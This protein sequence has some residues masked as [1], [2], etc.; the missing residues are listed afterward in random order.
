MKELPEFGKSFSEW[1][2]DRNYAKPAE[3]ENILKQAGYEN[4]EVYLTE[5]QAN[6]N[7]KNDYFVYLKTVDLR[8][9]QSTCHQNNHDLIC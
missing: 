7:S 9:Y 4:I 3:T 8:P 2:I 1:K 6:F 5:A